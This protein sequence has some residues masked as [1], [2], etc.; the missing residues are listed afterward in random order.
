[1]SWGVWPEYIIFSAPMPLSVHNKSVQMT[2]VHVRYCTIAPTKL[3]QSTFSHH[4]LILNAQMSKNLSFRQNKVKQIWK[5]TL[6][7]MRKWPHF[8][9]SVN[10]PFNV[11][12][13]RVHRYLYLSHGTFI[14]SSES[15]CILLHFIIALNIVWCWTKPC[16]YPWKTNLPR[17][18][19]I[20]TFKAPEPVFKRYFSM[21]MHVSALILD[22]VRMGYIIRYLPGTKTR[23]SPMMEWSVPAL[24]LT[25][26]HMHSVWQ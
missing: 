17:S 26:A 10:Y 20:L 5:K 6:R 23:P 15:F 1:M 19:R 11:L 24:C 18:C 4:L 2:S 21:N 16:L 14:H 13:K 9:L 7:L 8:H 12:F 3:M 25:Y 22:L